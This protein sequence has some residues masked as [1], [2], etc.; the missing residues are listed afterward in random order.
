M[1]SIT[2]ESVGGLEIKDSYGRE[3]TNLRI[4]VTRNCNLRCEYCHH[5]GEKDNKNNTMTSDEIAKI[6]SLAAKLGVEKVK[7]TGGEPLL[8]PDITEIIKKIREIKEIKEISMTTNGVLLNVKA[9]ELKKAGLNRVNVSLDTIN[10]VK[11]KNITGVDALKKVKE[12]IEKAVKENLTPVK[13]NMVILKDINSNEIETMIEWAQG[14]HVILQ[15]IELIPLGRLY[16]QYY[17]NLKE[18]ENKLLLTSTRVVEREM[19][20]RRKYYLKSG[21]EVEVVRPNHNSEFCANCTRI[22]LTSNGYLKP[23]LMRDDNLQDILTPLRRGESE[24]Q[25][26]ELFKKTIRMREPYYK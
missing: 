19:Q 16:Q 13:I 21:V 18:V 20:K 11:Y 10:P 2:V 12:G 24:D 9:A 25:L 23:C 15:L 22:R 6:T 4:S 8:R 3:I 7:I 14:K 17:Y 5:E 1:I 26:L